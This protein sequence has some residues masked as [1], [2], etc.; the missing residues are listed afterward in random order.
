MFSLSGELHKIYIIKIQKSF[1]S[2]RY[3]VI[4]F[5]DFIQDYYDSDKYY[6]KFSGTTLF[7]I[8]DN[9]TLCQLERFLQKLKIMI[10]IIVKVK[11]YCYL[12]NNCIQYNNIKE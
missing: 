8:P 9:T 2:L 1:I 3:I 6:Q 10:L 12:C 7:F 4:Q 11:L 5:N